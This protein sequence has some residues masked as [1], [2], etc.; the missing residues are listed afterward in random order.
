[1]TET[2]HQVEFQGGF[3]VPKIPSTIEETGLEQEILLKLLAKTLHTHGTMTASAMAWEIRLPVAV[4]STLVK[5]LQ[6]LQLIEAKGLTGAD[7]RGEVRYAL[8]GRGHDYA[9]D[10][11]AQSQYVGPAPVTLEDFV[12]QIQRQ[13]IG[14]E[15]LSRNAIIAALS[16]LVLP[17]SLVDTIGPA[18]NSA[19]SILLYGEPGNGKTSIA[20]AIGKA[21]RDAIY[22][23]YSFIVGGQ[24]INFFDSAV[25]TPVEAQD[26]SSSKPIFD[27][28]WQLC[29]RPLVITG[30]E[31]TLDM[32]DLAFDA[33]S[34]VYEAPVHFKATGG[35]FVV[36]DF[37]RQRTDPQ[38]VLNRWIVPLERGFDQLTLNTGRKFSVPFDQLVIFS[39]NIEPKNLADAGALRRLYYKIEIPTPTAADYHSIF[40][41]VC[42]R[43][44]IEFNLTIFEKFFTEY[45]LS[46]GATP[47]G[48]HPRY[49]IDFVIST[50]QF[51]GEPPYMNSTL[52]GAAWQNLVPR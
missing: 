8:G 41:D 4:V 7:M 10:A 13:S 11:M 33:A 17:E 25:H 2:A 22:L 30:G 34:R 3:Y 23:P 52:L 5:E 44:G 47:A 39:T 19:R 38:A 36:D 37:G 51:R 15:R 14:T 50:C 43:R 40:V 29:R 48:H 26:R 18:V 20:E 9:L 1:M 45:Y 31:L 28:R 21:F 49:L 32:L 12:A 35:V 24:I 16:H 27:Q 6:R 42:E 46:K